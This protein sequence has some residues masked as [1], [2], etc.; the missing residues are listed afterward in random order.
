MKQR[1]NAA[2]VSLEGLK[3][4]DAQQALQISFAKLAQ[5]SKPFVDGFT[6]FLNQITKFAGFIGAITAGLLTYKTINAA[7]IA[8]EK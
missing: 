5:A 3:Q 2:G 4:L 8:Q 6:V 1:A 7:I